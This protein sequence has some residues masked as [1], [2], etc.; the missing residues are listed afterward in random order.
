MSHWLLWWIFNDGELDNQVIFYSDKFESYRGTSAL[1]LILA[2]ILS[3]M[4]I[5]IGWTS[6]TAGLI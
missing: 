5:F 4:F 1:L 3:I 2:A 6:S